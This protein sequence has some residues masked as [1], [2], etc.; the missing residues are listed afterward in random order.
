MPNI[1][2]EEISACRVLLSY[3]K[4]LIQQPKEI[5]KTST[6][7]PSDNASAIESLA[8]SSTPCVGQFYSKPQCVSPSVHKSKRKSKKYKGNKKEISHPPD[9]IRICLELNVII[10]INVCE[11]P[12][13]IMIVE[14]KLEYYESLNEQAKFQQFSRNKSDTNSSASLNRDVLRTN[15][16][17]DIKISNNQSVNVRQ[18]DLITLQRT[19]SEVSGV[20]ASL[21]SVKIDLVGM[22]AV[23]S[24]SASL[25]SNIVSR[26]VAKSDSD[27]ESGVGE[28]EDRESVVSGLS[29]AVDDALFDETLSDHITDC[30]LNAPQTSVISENDPTISTDSNFSCTSSGCSS[31]GQ[32]VIDEVIN[33]INNTVF[34]C[35]SKTT[36]MEDNGQLSNIPLEISSTD[37]RPKSL[38]SCDPIGG[39]PPV[40]AAS[41]NDDYSSEKSSS[42]ITPED[43]PK[44]EEDIIPMKRCAS[45]TPQS[46]NTSSSSTPQS[47]NTSSSSTP[48]FVNTSSSSTHQSVNTSSSSTP[49]SVNTSSSSTPQ[50]THSPSSSTPQSTHSPSSSSPLSSSKSVVP[51]VG[52][53]PDGGFCALPPSI[54]IGLSSQSSSECWNYAAAARAGEMKKWIF[55]YYAS[56]YMMTSG[57]HRRPFEGRHLV[58]C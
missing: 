17:R 38:K 13:A 23:D 43:C 35:T 56:T 11:V 4:S 28:E 21:P 39:D 51:Q 15:E 22:D 44:M 20:Q 10:P 1:Y 14:E 55:G 37:P 34:N 45:S 52:P 30:S 8:S 49:Q 50:S 5:S 40:M 29:Q 6:V 12:N 7:T 16:D 19:H 27:V 26:N 2:K 9:V 36:K 46:V 3:M 33:G 48:Q 42:T 54:F 53:S 25:Y 57:M 58:W 41:E 47:V 18:K 32:T 31:A 24:S